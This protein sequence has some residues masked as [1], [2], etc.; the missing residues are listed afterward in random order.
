VQ[1][2]KGTPVRRGSFTKKTRE[3][4]KVKKK[5]KGRRRLC[6]FLANID[7]TLKKGVR[8]DVLIKK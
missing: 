6:S 1:G 3:K 4:E 5:K 7:E 2:K 8:K